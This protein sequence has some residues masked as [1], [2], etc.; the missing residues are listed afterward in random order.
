M[1]P[2]SVKGLP[3]TTWA[4]VPSD[5]TRVRAFVHKQDGVA[6][7][8]LIEVRVKRLLQSVVPGRFVS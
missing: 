2:I 5:T 6:P 1:P 3:T 8:K 4:P 7:S